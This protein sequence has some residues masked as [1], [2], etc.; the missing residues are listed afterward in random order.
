MNRDQ[1]PRGAIGLSSLIAMTAARHRS[2]EAHEPTIENRRATRDY[3]IE[4]TLE[5]GMSLRGTEIKSIRA[6]LVSLAE[7]YIEATSQPPALR[8]RSVHIAEYAPAGEQ[9]QH[10]PMRTRALLAH[11]REIVRL[12]EAV[13]AKGV[14]LVPLKIHFVRGRA[15]LVIGLARGRKQHDKR[16]E[17]AKREAAREID[18]ALRRR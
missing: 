5:C 14:T 8:L 18:R 3:A 16:D 2:P 9:R 10:E 13:R 17:I 7:G 4:E 11:R 15:K 12:A 1:L 6:G